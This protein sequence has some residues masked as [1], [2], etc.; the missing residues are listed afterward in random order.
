MPSDDTVID[1]NVQKIWKRYE[2]WAGRE[3]GSQ[4]DAKRNSYL[5]G[6]R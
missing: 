4:I 3:R 6:R 1:E 2:I 5:D